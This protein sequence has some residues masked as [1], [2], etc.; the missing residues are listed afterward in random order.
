MNAIRLR[1]GKMRAALTARGQAGFVWNQFKALADRFFFRRGTEGVASEED[2]KRAAAEQYQTTLRLL[3]NPPEGHIPIAG[4]AR[5]INFGAITTEELGAVRSALIQRDD[6]GLLKIAV[7]T[8][9]SPSAESNSEL[10]NAAFQMITDSKDSGAWASMVGVAADSAIPVCRTDA[11]AGLERM[12]SPVP[13]GLNRQVLTENLLQVV[14]NTPYTDTLK[15]AGEMLLRV[16]RSG[17]NELA[18]AYLSDEVS[19]MGRTSILLY[20]DNREVVKLVAAAMVRTIQEV[21]AEDAKVQEAQHIMAEMLDGLAA[22][23]THRHPETEQQGREALT[24]ISAF[25]DLIYSPT[26]YNQ[27]NGALET[28]YLNEMALA[29]AVRLGPDG[30]NRQIIREAVNGTALQPAIGIS[31]FE[32]EAVHG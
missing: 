29:D 16:N 7:A 14:E 25:A 17:A 15:A 5:V 4:P 19:L 12:A 26:P 31:R 9:D 28:A 30:A 32:K 6:T 20:S 11:V 10:R 21:A 13:A 8:L 2:A 24:L 22:I 18:A 3:S 1:T 27:H 23:R